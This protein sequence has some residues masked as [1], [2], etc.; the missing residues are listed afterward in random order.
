M[1]RKPLIF[2]QWNTKNQW[3]TTILGEVLAD[4]KLIFYFINLIGVKLCQN[5]SKLQLTVTVELAATF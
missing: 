2:E 1:R 3:F 5:Q 4:L